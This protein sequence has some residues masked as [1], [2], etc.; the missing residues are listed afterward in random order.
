VIEDCIVQLYRHI[1][2]MEQMIARLLA[3]MK[4]EMKA[5]REELTATLEAKLQ[6]NETKT[7][8]NLGEMMA[9][10]DAHYERMMSCLGKTEATDLEANAEEMQSVA[11]HEAVPKEDAA[12]KTG[13]ALNKRHRGRHLAAGRRR[14]PKDR[15]KGKGGCRKKLA[16][17]LRGTTRRAGAAWRKGRR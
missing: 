2:E 9:S 14:Q 11:V 8:A 5:D 15:T 12:V 4:A 7:D 3:E 16:A 1:M 6:A 10:L 13:R 17:A